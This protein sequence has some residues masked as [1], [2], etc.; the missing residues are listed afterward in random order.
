MHR[1]PNT[2][3]RGIPFDPATVR[4]VWN[5]GIPILGYDATEWRRD[6][7]GHIIRFQDYANEESS[8]G[9]HID[10]IRPVCMTGFDG[11]QNLEPLYWKTNIIKSDVYPFDSRA[12]NQVSQG[13]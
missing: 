7:F 2:N 6:P 12:L 9:W 13:W 8:F 4:A 11:L 1:K 3:I 10:H 5:R